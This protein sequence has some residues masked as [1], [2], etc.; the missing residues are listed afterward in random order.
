MIDISPQNQ[1]IVTMCG[2]RLTFT[3]HALRRFNQRVGISGHGRGFVA[4]MALNNA[5]AIF[6]DHAQNLYMWATVKVSSGDLDMLFIIKDRAVVL[7]VLTEDML[8][9]SKLKALKLYRILQ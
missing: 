7:T 9:R 1:A 2:M 3:H 8:S 5:K 4:A 6:I